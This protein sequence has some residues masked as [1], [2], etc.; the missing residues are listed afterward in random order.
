MLMEYKVCPHCSSHNIVR[1]A[2]TI[3]DPVEKEWT[4]DDLWSIYC[5]DC[6]ETSHAPR[7]YVAV[8]DLP[9]GPG[10]QRDKATD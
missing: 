3:W 8:E 5:V 2:W 7:T 4:V 10:T 9:D 1:D 6:G